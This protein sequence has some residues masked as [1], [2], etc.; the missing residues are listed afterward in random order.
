MKKNFLLSL[1]F[2]IPFISLAQDVE[3]SFQ[4]NPVGQHLYTLKVF[5]N[6]AVP[7]A[8][9]CS[10]SFSKFSEKDTLNLAIGDWY[11]GN[12]KDFVYGIDYSMSDAAFS[13]YLYHQI[14]ILSPQTYLF[15][16]VVLTDLDNYKSKSVEF[17]LSYTKELTKDEVNTYLSRKPGEGVIMRVGKKRFES[18]E[19][20][21]Q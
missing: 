16:N 14:L 8:I 4:K 13:E 20:K 17:A 18:I 21:I 1:Y 2:L 12:G 19:V 3:V 11:N 15:T 7:L 6:S 9:R 10:P 5:N